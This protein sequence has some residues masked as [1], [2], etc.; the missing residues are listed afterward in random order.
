V[1]NKVVNTQHLASDPD[2]WRLSGE[3]VDGGTE[4]NA[5]GKVE[6]R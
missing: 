3:D 1:E 6:T 4:S 5:V 2:V